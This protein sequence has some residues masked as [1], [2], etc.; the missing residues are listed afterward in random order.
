MRTLLKAAFAFGRF[1]TR[2]HNLFQMQCDRQLS[3]NQ[4]T[5]CPYEREKIRKEFDENGYTILRKVITGKVLEEVQRHVDWLLE[6]YPDV[7]PEHL[8]HP[9]L[10]RGGLTTAFN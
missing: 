7:P 9:I 10:R 3:T 8:H 5:K 1:N 4:V 2:F 6:R